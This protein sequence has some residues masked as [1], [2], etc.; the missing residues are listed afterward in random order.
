MQIPASVNFGITVIAL[1]VG[2]NVAGQTFHIFT[3]ENL[4]V[5]TFRPSA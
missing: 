3:I 4:T 2:M 5:R 1:I